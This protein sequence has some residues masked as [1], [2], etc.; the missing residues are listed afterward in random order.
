MVHERRQ[1]SPGPRRA[2]L[3][4]AALLA[5]P[6]ASR[7]QAPAEAAPPA[8]SAGD[9]IVYQVVP[10]VSGDHVTTRLA[11]IPVRAGD[12]QPLL[13]EALYLQIGR[14]DLGAEY[15]ARQ[16]RRTVLAGLG[17]AIIAGGLAWAATRP[18]P[19]ANMPLDEFR[20]AS[21]AQQSAVQTG[22]AVS[23][24]GALVATIAAFTDPNPV[25]EAERQRLIEAHNRSLP[26]GPG[27]T[28][29]S[30]STTPEARPASLSFQ[31]SGLPGGGLAGLAL[32]W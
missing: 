3:A 18:G 7:A 23:L 26:P 6:G 29:P 27:A 1:A 9:R 13:G 19:S 12:G 2:I 30:R 17:G 20:R 28:A 5:A 8:P 10:L 25:G 31:A 32:A 21:D 16:A 15:R 22:V 24:A 11:A 4:L 14:P